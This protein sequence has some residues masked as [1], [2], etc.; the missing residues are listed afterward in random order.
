MSQLKR[1]PTRSH[2]ALAVL[3]GFV[4]CQSARAQSNSVDLAYRPAPVNNPLKGLVPYQRPWER[5]PC[6]M[7]FNYLPLSSLVVGDEKYDWAPLE[8]ILNDI[9][10]RGRQ[11]VFRVFLEYPGKSNSIPRYLIDAGLKVHRYKNT[12]TAPLPPANVETPDYEDPNLRRC[13]RDY[14]TA[15]GQRYDG[16]P[17]IAYITAGLLGTWGEWH[18]YPRNDLWASKETQRVVLDAYEKA[19]TKT[20]VLLR[21]PAKE[22]H[23][24]QA[25]NDRRRLGYHDDSFAYA[26]LETGRQEDDWYF[27]PAMIA[28]G[29]T[30]KWKTQPIG[31]EIRPEVWGC[32]FD[33]DPCTRPSQSFAACRDQL[34]V[35]WLMDT[36]M[37]R[38]KESSQD[39]ID[40]AKEAVRKMGYEF[41]VTA[42]K[43]SGRT[44]EVTFR[45]TGI[46]PFYHQGWKVEVGYLQ[47][48]QAKSVTGTDWELTGIL[49][50]QSVRKTIVLDSNP[51]AG[52]VVAVRVANPMRGGI[53]VRFANLS[54]DRDL[55]AWLSVWQSAKEF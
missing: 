9:Q 2:I 37:F 49:P 21:Y 24:A 19:F 8:K 55:S 54:Q 43:L 35:T 34:H 33:Q 17:R 47:D 44:L 4:A 30:E 3:L 32:C 10:S 41:Q 39:R 12:N 45:N 46:A 11:T 25:A 16:D 14:I 31:G 7:E 22:G 23:Y 18:T 38:E 26:T 13:L 53:P 28:A 20:P 5:F 42:A 1:Q 40:R 36:G 52:V 50:G 29:A 15:L 27:Y 48:S 6:S 51:P